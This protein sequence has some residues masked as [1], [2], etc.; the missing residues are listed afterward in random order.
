ME[1]KV[2]TIDINVKEW[3]DKIN[4]NSY[5]AAIVTV[6]YGLEDS[7]EIKIPFEYG[8][9]EHSRYRALIEVSKLYPEFE[10]K[11]SQELRDAGVIIRYNK[12]TGCLKRDLKAFVS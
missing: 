9:G 11:S 1:T 8:Y 10:K 4:G 6:N 3:L 5:F 2:K 7:R 12:Q